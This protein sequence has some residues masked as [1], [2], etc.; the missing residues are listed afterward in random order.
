MMLGALFFLQAK[1]RRR[2]KEDKRR[3]FMGIV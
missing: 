3:G 1:S 2:S